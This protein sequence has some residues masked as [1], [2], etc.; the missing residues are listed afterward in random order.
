MTGRRA[1]RRMWCLA[2]FVL[3]LSSRSAFAAV[4]ADGGL[5]AD[6]G[7][8]GD[9]GVDGRDPALIE[10]FER[11]R[12]SRLM[13]ARAFD[14]RASLAREQAAKAT[15]EEARQSMLKNAQRLSKLADQERRLAGELAPPK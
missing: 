9:S 11:Q 6:G 3:V 14:A 1:A 13:Q 7:T 10:S 8:T 5:T 15:T 2:V 4:V 12:E